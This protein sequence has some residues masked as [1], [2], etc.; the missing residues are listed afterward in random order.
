V[1]YQNVLNGTKLT[2]FYVEICLTWFIS[3]MLAI[4]QVGKGDNNARGNIFS[5]GRIQECISF[6]YLVLD[7]YV[8][9]IW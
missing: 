5:L 6:D 3:K 1:L 4:P 8:F 9:A 2:G 7:R